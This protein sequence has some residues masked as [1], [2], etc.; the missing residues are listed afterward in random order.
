LV[1]LGGALGSVARY[2][3]SG[4]ALR[5]FGLG[6]PYGTLLVNVVGSYA[7]GIL[8]TIAIAGG[9]T[10]TPPDIR[11]FLVTGI[12]GGFTTFSAFSLETFTLARSGNLSGAVA[13]VVLSLVLCFVAVA[14]GYLSATAFAR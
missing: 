8:G 14:L 13:N 9:R 10:L 4:V 1:A 5:L 3:C 7:I 12:L 11:A 6:F 2:A